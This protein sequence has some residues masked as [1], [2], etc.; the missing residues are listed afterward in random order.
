MSWPSLP[1]DVDLA[2]REL[3]GWVRATFD[4]MGIVVCGSIVR[5]EGG[6]RSDLDVIVLHRAP[7]RL[8]DQRRFQGVPAE[9]FVNP[10]SAIRGYFAAEHARAR[11]STAHMLA[12]G[13]VV[14]ATEPVVG[15]LIV[16]ARSWLARTPE[17][18]EDRLVRLRYE[19]V[20]LLDDASDL[21][22]R[23]PTA[24]TLLLG[25]VVDRAIALVFWQHRLF[26]PPR[27]DVVRRLQEIDP[28]AAEL[29]YEYTSGAPEHRLWIV[30][31]LARHTS[32]TDTFF[33]WTSDRDPP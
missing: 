15:H 27:K 14:H 28:G 16:E 5:G 12:T 18:T 23:D 24:A 1:P 11:P 9:V 26:Q 3:V 6:P 31:A 8:R 25:Q 17:V 7:W 30:A 13:V 21:I 22:D 19:I 10:P 2:C 4:S 32:G 20:D 33:G 29:V